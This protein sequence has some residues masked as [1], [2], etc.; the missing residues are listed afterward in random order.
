MRR[1][2]RPDDWLSLR[3]AASFIGKEICGP[4]WSD[5]KLDKTNDSDRKV[6]RSD[7]YSVFQSVEVKIFIDDGAGPVNFPTIKA[8]DLC[9]H[10]DIQRDAVFFS[11]DPFPYYCSI[12]RR[13]LEKYLRRNAATRSSREASADAKAKARHAFI[14]MFRGPKTMTKN[15]A[16]DRVCRQFALSKKSALRAWREAS[17]EVLDTAWIKSGRPK[18]S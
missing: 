10:I 3:E 17:T 16:L 8:H 12:L 7:L 14:R 5:K 6:I 15:E 13:D 9:F 11:G 1:P 4:D 2:M 18:K